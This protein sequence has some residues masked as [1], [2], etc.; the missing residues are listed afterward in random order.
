MNNIILDKMYERIRLYEDIHHK[1]DKSN[2]G[3]LAYFEMA[4]SF[5][6]IIHRDGLVFIK[7]KLNHELNFRLVR[8]VL[9]FILAYDRE[10]SIGFYRKMVEDQNPDF[11]ITEPYGLED[12]ISEECYKRMV[13]FCDNI[14]KKVNKN[15]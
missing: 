8:K 5:V 9:G 2:I 14:E 10:Y 7:E 13:L 11:L 3:N 6:E 4:V 12:F 1:V 15:N